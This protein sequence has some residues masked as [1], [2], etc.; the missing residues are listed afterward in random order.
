MRIVVVGNKADDGAPTPSG[1]AGGSADSDVVAEIEGIEFARANGLAGHVLT[2]AKTAANVDEAF[3][4]VARATYAA[5][6][7]GEVEV[8]NDAHGVRERGGGTRG[9]AG[10]SVAVVTGSGGGDRR[11]ATGS[12][13]CCS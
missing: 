9:P 4:T 7:R 6:D 5:I 8:G 13:P 3:I 2:S 10:G 1:G 12:N 11:W